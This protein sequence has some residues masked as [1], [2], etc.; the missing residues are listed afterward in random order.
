MLLY[1]STS[2]RTKTP[3]NPRGP[4]CKG[5]LE[6]GGVHGGDGKWRSADK[7]RGATASQYKTG[8]SGQLSPSAAVSERVCMDPWTTPAL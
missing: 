2:L 3:Q 1:L 5:T 8:G 4:K 7:G 6:A